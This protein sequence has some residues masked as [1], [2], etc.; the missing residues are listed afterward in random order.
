M[1]YF[2]INTIV[3][4]I[5]LPPVLYMLTNYG[6][7]QYLTSSFTHTLEN[8]YIGSTQPLFNGTV[9]L[10]NA[11]QG[12]IDT[13]V[14]DNVFIRLGAQAIISV[15]TKDGRLLYPNMFEGDGGV[16][17]LMTQHHIKVARENYALLDQGLNLEVEVVIDHTSLLA[18]AFL[19]IYMVG[20]LLFFSLVYYS[21]LRRFRADEAAQ[22]EEL[23]RLAASEAQNRERLDALRQSRE[24]LLE[25]IGSLKSTYVREKGRADRNEEEMI[26]EIVGLE[27]ELKENQTVISDSQ[28]KIEALENMIAQLE[29]RQSGEK[30]QKG[31][32]R[33]GKRFKALYKNLDVS[34]RAVSGYTR[35]N[36]DMKIKAEEVIHQL[37]NAP[38][39]VTIKR[40]VFGK[41]NR[42][43][44]FEVIFAYKGRLYFRKTGD[45]TIEV[46][47]IGTKHTQNKDLVFLDKL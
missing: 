14:A 30:E 28:A 29:G 9:T 38:D 18:I 31:A 37:N 16:D 6:L 33:L 42:E 35:L 17:G 19:S 45:R 34:R 22:R 43:T 24:K 20:A 7:Q 36:P 39:K 26:A 21:G 13:F 3:L 32:A 11:I 8:T 27:D 25:D 12:N 15:T 2:P 40:K 46:L 47:A 41:K 4:C 10:Q 5:L 23:E 1:R 44:V